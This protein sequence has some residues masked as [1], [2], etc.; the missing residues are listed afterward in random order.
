MPFRTQPRGPW[1]P[2]ALALLF[3]EF[4]LAGPVTV[5]G[6]A[7]ASGSEGLRVQIDAGAC[8]AGDNDL[9]LSGRTFS[10]AEPET[11]SACERIRADSAT[12]TGAAVKFDAGYQVA[13]GGGFGVARGSQFRVDTTPSRVRGGFVADHS[14]AGEDH[15]AVRFLLNAQNLMLTSDARLVLLEGA[16]DSGRSW[17]EL[18][19]TYV[20]STNS[21][22]LSV[23]A[24]QDGGGRS[25]S[26]PFDLTDGWHA[27]EVEWWAS[28]P[29]AAD[30]RVEI[31][32]DGAL[33]AGLSGLDNDTG[34]I[35]QARWGVMDALAT[36]SG[37]LDLDEFVSRRAGPIGPP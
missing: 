19:M 15:Y 22:R 37:H 21:R 26:T 7:A 3:A 10:A 34:R 11:Y 8:N 30:G 27:V 32:L 18:V 36:T 13:L 20:D 2:W 1:A 25:G 4:A 31:R 29:G 17:L 14:P 33:Q 24:L 9:D 16:D 12:V 5:T 28:A 35:D 23:S 6:S